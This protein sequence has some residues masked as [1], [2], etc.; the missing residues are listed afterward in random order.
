MERGQN[1]RP[2]E[3]VKIDPNDS[4]FPATGNHSP[5]I[6]IRAHLAGLAMQGLFSDGMRE[7]ERVAE[8]AVEYTDALI[9]KLNE[10]RAP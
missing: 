7:P 9:E 1:L 2:H 8:L 6:T 3:T 10:T 4:A 5:G